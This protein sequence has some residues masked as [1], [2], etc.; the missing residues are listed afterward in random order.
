VYLFE[1]WLMT[2]YLLFCGKIGG[3][4]MFFPGSSPEAQWDSLHRIMTLPDETLVFP[5]HDYYGGPGDRPHS[6]IG[7]ERE[8][9]PFL[10][11]KDFAE[12]CHLKENWT[13]YK[14]EHGLR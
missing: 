1:G 13:A 3:T 8:H 9:N 14:Q 11:C 12:F 5:G 2:G 4:G 6:T 7:Y 10:M